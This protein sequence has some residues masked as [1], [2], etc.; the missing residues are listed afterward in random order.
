MNKQ[1]RPKFIPE[2]GGP[3]YS[4]SVYTKEQVRACLEMHMPLIFVR[5]EDVY[6][7]FKEYREIVLASSRIKPNNKHYNVGHHRIYNLDLRIK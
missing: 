5:D 3:T 2:T 4:V 7:E 1:P 6:N